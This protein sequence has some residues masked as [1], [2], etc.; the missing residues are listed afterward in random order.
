MVGFPSLSPTL[1]ID[2]VE[3]TLDTA[4]TTMNT[5]GNGAY[6]WDQQNLGNSHLLMCKDG[7]RL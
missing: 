5:E 7:A 3:D 6:S 2:T 4:D 1:L